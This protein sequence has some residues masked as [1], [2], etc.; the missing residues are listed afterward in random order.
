MHKDGDTKVGEGL[1]EDNFRFMSVDASL[2][3]NIID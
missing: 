1:A 2:H 3:D